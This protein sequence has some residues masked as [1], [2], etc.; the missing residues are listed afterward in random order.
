MR[1][2]T[3]STPPAN[4]AER[5][6]AAKGRSTGT[7]GRPAVPRHAGPKEQ[8]KPPRTRTDFAARRSG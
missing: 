3:P 4:R 7:D 1:T 6:A 5:R 2:T 8:T